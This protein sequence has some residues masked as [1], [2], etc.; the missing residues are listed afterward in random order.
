MKNL[1]FVFL[2]GGLGSCCRYAL[3]LL[4]NQAESPFPLGTFTA[5]ALSCVFLGFAT[6]FVLSNLNFSDEVR[7]IIMVGF[8]GGF[9]TFSTFDNELL[10]LIKNGKIYHALIY[11]GTSILVGLLALLLGIKLGQKFLLS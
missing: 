9:S 6:V 7:L 8:C 2:G 11:G 4:L 3:A 5:N 10:G 1:I